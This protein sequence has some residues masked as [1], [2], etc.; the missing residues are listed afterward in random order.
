MKRNMDS[1]IHTLMYDL[2]TPRSIAD[3]SGIAFG[4]T[5]FYLR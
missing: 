2:V 1:D 3:G 5:T 4:G